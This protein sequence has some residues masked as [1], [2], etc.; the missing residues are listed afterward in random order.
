M[1]EASEE[2]ERLSR[3]ASDL[4]F[5][6]A[7]DAAEVLEQESVRL[8]EI[9]SGAWERGRLAGGW[10]TA[11][12]TTSVLERMSRAKSQGIERGWSNWPGI[13]WR[14]RCATPPLVVGSTSN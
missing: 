11:V 8:D 5:L 9:V 7:T 13:W 10:L 1:R 3:L 2:I 14:M 4:L 6:A 12:C